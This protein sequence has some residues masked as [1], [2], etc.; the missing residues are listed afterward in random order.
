MKEL[1]ER[2]RNLN[3]GIPPGQPVVPAPELIALNV[4]MERKLCQM[5]VSTLAA[6]AGVSVSTVERIERGEAVSREVLDK[7][8][9]V[10]GKEDGYYTA[11]RIR[12]TPEETIAE[13]N[14][15]YA[16]LEA[17]EVREL[18][19][20]PQV[21][22]LGMCCGCL[23]YCDE[24]TEEAKA[25][26]ENLWEW[27]DLASFVVSGTNEAE[28]RRR[29]LYASVLK[30]GENLKKKGF[31]VLVGKMPAPQP[32]F[33]DWNAAVVCIKNKKTDPGASKR[34]LIFVDR[35]LV[36]REAETERFSWSEAS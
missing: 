22:D 30:A 7:V 18:K 24:I 4:I 19:T 13:L 10:F 3:D 36:S 34:R 8:G 17:V 2:I 29:E 25:D 11:P 5:K 35:R 27:L 1:L 32:G 16:N 28:G 15:K 9:R 20:Q 6:M 31:V 23:V 26:V 14:Q 12:K 21:R 33:P